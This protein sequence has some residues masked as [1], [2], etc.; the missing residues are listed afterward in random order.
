[1]RH[2]IDL[3]S[4]DEVKK[5]KTLGELPEFFQGKHIYVSYGDYDD[6]TLLDIAR[7]ILA[8]DGILERQINA[9]VKYVI[10]RRMWNPDFE[11]VAWRFSR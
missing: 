8:Y 2:S 6:S 5:K 7:V 11:K 10:T 9:D 1:M 3:L 4:V